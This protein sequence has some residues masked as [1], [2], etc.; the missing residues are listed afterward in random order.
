MPLAPLTTLGVG[1]SALWYTRAESIESVRA[2]WQWALA[3]RLPVLVLGGGSNLIVAD[4]GWPGLVLHVA[5]S[6]IAREQSGPDTLMR[7]G[8]G[9][10]WDQVVDDAVGLGLAG[11]ECLSGI[12][13]TAGATPI[14][15]VGAY[16]QEVG[17]V[18]DT[19][20]ALDRSTGRID[21][22]SAADCQFGYRTSRFKTSDAGRFVVC[23]VTFRLREGKP[24]VVYPDVV[25]HMREHAIMTPTVADVRHAVLAIRRR[26]GMVLDPEDPDTRSVGSFFTNPVLSAE[27]FARLQR[28][29]QMEVPCFPASDGAVKVP[30]A[31]L[32][33]HAGFR[34]GAGDSA[35]G[36]STKH[37]LAIVNRGGAT[38]REVVQFAVQIKREVASRFDVHLVTEPVFAGFAEDPQVAYLT[39]GA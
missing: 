32:I 33:E 12:P 20:G 36:L 29:V 1:G 34:R 26:K 37:P 8:A 17:T 21:R 7:C 15:N 4:Q 35:V 5:V 31:W 2:A 19:V 23:D 39:R 28:S 18:I 30:A 27:A 38:A 10:N 25:T 9:G 24:T 22:I 6:G 11:I 16:G 13:G 3:E 14:Q